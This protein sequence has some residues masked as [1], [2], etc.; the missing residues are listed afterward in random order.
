MSMTGCERCN[1][2]SYWPNLSDDLHR[3]HHAL[4]NLAWAVV[5]EIR[6]HWRPLAVVYGLVLVAAA[7]WG[8]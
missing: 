1:Q 5:A 4:H 6:T 3:L 7:I 2:N 8:R